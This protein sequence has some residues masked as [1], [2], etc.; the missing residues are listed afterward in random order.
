MK[1]IFTIMTLLLTAHAAMAAA[2]MTNVWAEVE[3][4]PTGSGK[5]YLTSND[6]E[7]LMETGWGD[8]S[9]SKFTIKPEGESTYTTVSN[10]EFIN[11]Y[12]PCFYGI[13]QV[14]GGDD[15]ECV[16]LVKQIRE[17]GNY[18]DEDY[19]QG[20][21]AIYAKTPTTSTESNAGGSDYSRNITIVDERGAYV[22][23]NSGRD[24]KKYEE[25]IV[26]PEQEWQSIKESMSDE[27]YYW[28]IHNKTVAEGAWPEQ[29]T[30]IYALFEKKVSIEMPAEGQMLFSSDKNLKIQ[31]GSGLQA[32]VVYKVVNGEGQLKATDSIPANVGVVLKGEPGQTYKLDRIPE[33]KTLTVIDANGTRKY[34]ALLC[35]IFGFYP[36]DE[37]LYRFGN[38]DYGVGFYKMPAG[39]R[40][41]YNY[42]TMAIPGGTPPE[43]FT[44]EGFT[45]GIGS[46][47]QETS[48]LNPQASTLF[49]LQGRR[50]TKAPAKGVYIKDGR[51]YVRK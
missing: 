22:N 42:L 38:Y 17:D 34:N 31:K 41:D 46:V 16:G 40:P 37:I 48:N 21:P 11:F 8:M 15:Y 14:D 39:Q 28:F 45:T 44:I 24:G 36:E 13:V 43:F 32:Y 27:E 3:A 50:L 19:Y 6:V 12:I 2:Y 5:I 29:P 25:Q 51:K 30:K 10:G 26:I 7:P 4:Y 33:P 9:A 1:R 49:D 47:T 20:G 18:T 23:M 35:E